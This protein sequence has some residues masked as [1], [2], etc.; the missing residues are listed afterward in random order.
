MSVHVEE[1]V[2]EVT[3]EPG[4]AEAGASEPAKWEDKARVYEALAQIARDRL[5]TAAEGYDD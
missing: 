5:R 2:S 4:S 1:M 3:A